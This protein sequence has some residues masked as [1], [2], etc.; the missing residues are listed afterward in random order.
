MSDFRN[1]TDYLIDYYAVLG[2]EKIADPETIKQARLEMQ[3]KY[4]P[5]RYEGLAPE[6]KTQAEA[7]ARI[8]QEAYETLSDPEKRLT[9]DQKLANWRGPISQNGNPVVDL[10]SPV[11]SS[12]PLIIGEGQ[13][14]S[15]DFA[16][17]SGYDPATFALI[18]EMYESTENPPPTLAAAYEEQLSRRD[19]H[20]ALEEQM[21][22]K[23]IGFRNQP[24]VNS[25]STAYQNEVREQ[26]AQASQIVSEI[27]SRILLMLQTGEVK[28]LVAGEGEEERALTVDSPEDMERRCVE[29]KKRFEAAAEGIQKLAEERGRLAGKKLAMVRLEY[30]PEQ[31]ILFSHLAVCASFG[32]KHHWFAFELDGETVT[33][34]SEQDTPE[35]MDALIDP[36]VASE[37]IARGWNVAFLELRE[38][39]DCKE[40][41]QFAAI[42]HFEKLLESD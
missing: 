24:T 25:P 2:V 9:Y 19:L 17:F 23:K 31:P 11:F 38:G 33:V 18:E 27:V 32:E 36:A 7:R 30:R 4:H 16:R 39:L 28:L 37:W 21:A 3:K 29:A 20:L 35:N 13:D 5:D 6:F 22:W 8:I 34:N 1:G 42:R 12:L 14:L 26:L 40:Q 15:L 10:R 41:M